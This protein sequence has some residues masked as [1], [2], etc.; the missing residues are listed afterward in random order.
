MV[1]DRKLSEKDSAGSA[2]YRTVLAIPETGNRTNGDCAA[3]RYF[4]QSGSGIR[5]SLDSAKLQGACQHR[6]T[7]ETFL[8]HTG[9][10]NQYALLAAQTEMAS[11][12]ARIAGDE[13]VY[14]VFMAIAEKV[15]KDRG[16]SGVSA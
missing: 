6:F 3:G 11:L 4:E 7:V 15:G 8:P 14:P 12:H 9:N 10:P 1:A 13:D 16:Q 5:A 2:V